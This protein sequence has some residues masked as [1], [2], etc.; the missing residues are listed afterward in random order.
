[1]TRYNYHLPEELIAKNPRVERDEARLF[2]YETKTGRITL[3][4][5]KNLDRYLPNKA[6]V[7]LNE[8]KV[9]PAR[10]TFRKS[11][12]GNVEILF[13][14]DEWQ[15][16][17]RQVRGMVD[18]GVKIGEFL[19]VGDVYSIRAVGQEENIF[20]FELQFPAAD[21]YHL[22]DRCGTT[23]IPKYIKGTTLPEQ[24]LRK[25]YQTIFANIA[26]SIAAPTA[27]LH[28]TERVFRSL[29]AKGISTAKISLNVGLGTFRP[30][31]KENLATGKLHREYFVVPEDTAKE[32]RADMTRVAV[33]TTATRALESWALGKE[34]TTDLF[35]RPPF[36]FKVVD[37]LITNFH[38]PNS[39]LMMLVEAFLQFKRSPAPLV[40]LYE[41]AILEKFLF[42][43][44]G[45]SMLIL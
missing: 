32:L 15:P 37:C 5:F 1:M 36:D 8:T 13:L 45:D 3:D 39:S 6:L 26:G 20:T 7:L 33:G 18:R 2:V 38:L 44:F 35:I 34:G 24:D 41:R 4:V 29:E 12:G 9:V 14:M 25:R 22:L 28:F 19:T 42:Y 23:P 10:V 40:E 11:T 21:F 27:S 17:Q 16:G 30:V 31:T 43:S